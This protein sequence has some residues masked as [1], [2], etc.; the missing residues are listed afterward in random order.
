[1]YRDIVQGR[2]TIIV[3]TLAKV[4]LI[5]PPA[6]G[7]AVVDSSSVAYDNIEVSR[8][9]AQKLRI[10]TAIEFQPK[11]PEMIPSGMKTRRRTLAGLR[12]NV[13]F[14]VY[15]RPMVQGRR[16]RLEGS[17]SDSTSSVLRQAGD[18]AGRIAVSRLSWSWDSDIAAFEIFYFMGWK[19][20]D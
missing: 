15:I 8:K 10:K 18:S 6:I 5:S 13:I 9:I 12:N 19:E 17:L 3:V 7:P 11:T 1:M 2:P 14:I 16:E 20:G 4:A